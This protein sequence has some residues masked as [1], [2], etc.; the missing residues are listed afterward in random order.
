MNNTSKLW[1]QEFTERFELISKMYYERFFKGIPNINNLKV[2][3]YG[4]GIGQGTALLKNVTCYDI[5]K[6][7]IEVAKNYGINII[8][9]LSLIK[10][11]SFDIVFSSMMLDHCLNPK[12]EL[13]NIYK[14]LKVGGKVIIILT[15]YNFN[16]IPKDGSYN[17]LEKEIKFNKFDLQPN[18]YYYNWNFIGLN[19]LL[20]SVGFKIKENK[21]VGYKGSRFLERFNLQFETYFKLI[22]FIGKFFRKTQMYIEA[23]KV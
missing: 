21:F 23:I 19:N 3:D 1:Y 11:N 15:D 14:K 5:N 4:C 16:K 9:N 6:D 18:A 10:N 20:I 17:H 2:L 12:K 8:N 22:N 13:E 7:A